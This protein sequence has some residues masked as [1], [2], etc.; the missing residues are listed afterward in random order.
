MNYPGNDVV[1]GYHASA[2][3]VASC[4]SYCRSTNNKYF[5]YRRSDGHCW[6][7]SIVTTR[8]YHSDLDSGE[9]VCG[10][11]KTK[12]SII[13][14]I[15]NGDNNINSLQILIAPNVSKVPCVKICPRQWPLSF[16]TPEF[17]SIIGKPIG[18]FSRIRFTMLARARGTGQ[19]QWTNAQTRG[20]EFASVIYSFPKNCRVTFIRRVLQAQVTAR[21]PPRIRG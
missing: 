18:S 20:S 11:G 3:N 12:Y 1:W 4:Q 5:T 16:A 13:F 2:N 15:S 10:I 6:C 19:V 21:R 7:K 9:A 17:Q 14:C 8:S